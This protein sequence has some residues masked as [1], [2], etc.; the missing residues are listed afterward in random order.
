MMVV[1]A[2]AAIAEPNNIAFIWN[3]IS[4]ICPGTKQLST[5]GTTGSFTNMES[6]FHDMPLSNAD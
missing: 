6:S 3:L 4:A 1:Q 5:T 2:T